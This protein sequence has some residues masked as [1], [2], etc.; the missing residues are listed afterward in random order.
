MSTLVCPYMFNKQKAGKFVDQ[1]NEAPR[2]R[3]VYQVENVERKM[4]A[5]VTIGNGG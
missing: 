1:V 5:V 4:K 3:A 2:S